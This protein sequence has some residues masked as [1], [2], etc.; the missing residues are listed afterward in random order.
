[1]SDTDRAPGFDEA[2]AYLDSFIDYERRPAKEARDFGLDRIRELLAA[3]GSPHERVGCLHV[4]GTKGKGSTAAMVAS[5]LVA[6]G[7]RSGLY[8]SPHLVDIRERIRVDGEMIPR[9]A[10]AGL[11]ARTRPYLDR[12]S[13][14]ARNSSTVRPPTYF[15]IMTHI[16]FLHFAECEVDVAILEVGMG[17]RLDATN[18]VAKP[19]ACA[20]TNISLDHTDILG[21]TLEEIAREKAGILKE[22]SPAVVAPQETSAEEAIAHAARQ[23]GAPLWWVGRDV[24]LRM[25]DDPAGQGVFSVR[26]PTCTYDGLSI[27]LAGAHQRE[28]AC[29]AVGLVELARGRGLGR[30]TP[31]A[32]REGL[33][34]VRWPGRFQEVA[35]RPVTILDGAHNPAS[36]EAL[37]ATLAERFGSTRPVYVLSI[38]SDKE[39]RKMIGALAGTAGAM[40]LTSSGSP[41][42]L[43]PDDLAGE[44]R[45]AGV[46]TVVVE[47]DA[48]AALEKARSTAGPDGLVVATGS[49]YLVGKL[50]PL[51]GDAPP[52]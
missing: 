25:Q 33:A 47:E 38:A 45:R 22:G 49:L 10:F 24:D 40:V 21:G 1:M 46:E 48:V 44:A 34:R 29:V 43:A 35:S 2:L 50:L 28:N 12:I 9:G 39:W 11:V 41:R 3:L 18:V 52:A 16:A 20:I 36:V 13:E 15:E 4:A 19:L 27:P 17:G 42:A 8:T 23:V 51:F 37:L 32:V 6:S 5:V 31:D 26:T 14:E 30:V 7:Y